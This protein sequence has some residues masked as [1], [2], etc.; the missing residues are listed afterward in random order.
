MTAHQQIVLKLEGFDHRVLDQSVKDIVHTVKRTGA[1]VRGPIPMPRKIQRFTV[2]RSSHID[3]K[4]REQFEIRHHTRLMFIDPSP[5]TIDA[6]M[7]LDLP[8]GVEVKIK[9]NG[10]AE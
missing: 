7:K 3:K 9:L 1:E 10:G 4:S 2:N 5:Q 8:S 6:L